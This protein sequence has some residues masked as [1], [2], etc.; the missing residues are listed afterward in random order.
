MSPE[1]CQFVCVD[2][3]NPDGK[4]CKREAQIG[5]LCRL[6]ARKAGKLVTCKHC[7]SEVEASSVASTSVRLS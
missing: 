1:Q 3:N 4:Q 6:H 7:G 2:R 5:T